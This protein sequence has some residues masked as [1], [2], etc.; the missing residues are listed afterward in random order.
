M[1]IFLGIV[2]AILI[3][4]VIQTIACPPGPSREEL[5]ARR[6]DLLAQQERLERESKAWRE[7]LIKNHKVWVGMTKAQLLQSW[8]EPEWGNQTVTAA[9]T[10]DQ[11]HYKHRAFPYVYLDNDVVT[12]LQQ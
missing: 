1:K 4:L 7:E 11:W 5:L 6:A 12:A 8:G 2:G 3:L 9:G 10:R